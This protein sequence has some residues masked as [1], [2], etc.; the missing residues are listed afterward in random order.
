MAATPAFGI[1]GLVCIGVLVVAAIAGLIV[2][3]SSSERRD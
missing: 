1:L 2:W 3:L